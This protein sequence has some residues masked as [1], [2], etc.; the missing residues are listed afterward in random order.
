MS[1]S[2]HAWVPQ[3]CTLPSAELPVRAAEFD[4]LFAMALRGQERLAP[5]RL[6]WRL[7]PAA[8]SAARD[9]TGRESTC[10]SFFRFTFAPAGDVVLLDV[11]VPAAQAS[12]LDVLA[13]R[14]AAGMGS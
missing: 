3:D 9:L 4:R 2:D 10:C 6:R 8:E 5:T 13:E 7:D 12:V 14:A 11:E 1:M